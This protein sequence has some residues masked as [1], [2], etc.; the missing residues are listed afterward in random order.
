MHELS[1]AQSIV[2]LAEE[3]A[4]TRKASAIEEIELEIGELAGVEIHA[5]EFALE[6][7][8]KGTMLEKAHIVRR[9]IEG[10]AF[11]SDCEKNFSINNLFTPCP[12]CGSYPVKILKG[13]ELR[14]KSIVI[15]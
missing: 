1:I 7:C 2:D 10:E 3:Q 15:A 6:S 4:K 13:R 11:C 8:V 14:L 9:D 12:I 5:L